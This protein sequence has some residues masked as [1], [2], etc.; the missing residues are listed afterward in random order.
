MLCFEAPDNYARTPEPK[1]QST[2]GGRHYPAI[3]MPQ[4]PSMT[5]AAHAPVPGVRRAP[6]AA[7]SVA[8][9]ILALAIIPPATAEIPFARGSLSLT[10]AL[11]EEYDSNI[12]LNQYRTSDWHTT[13]TP[14]VRLVRDAGL[15]R[16]E[17]D[18]G[19]NIQRF[20]RNDQ[21]NSTDPF[22]NASLRFTEEETRLTG[23]ASGFY[24]RVSEA[25]PD[26]NGRSRVEEKNGKIFLGFFPAQKLGYRVNG[27][28]FDQ[29]F[30]NP[31][32]SDIKTYSLG[33][34]ARYHYSEKF[35]TFV[36]VGKRW[37]DTY[38]VPVGLPS[39]DSED[40]KFRVGVEGDLLAKVSGQFAV[41][42]VR[43]TFSTTM[44][45]ARS[46]LLFDT[47]LTWRPDDETSVRLLVSRDFDT[48]PID[49][50]VM[51]QV[52]G[53]ELHRRIREKLGAT[54]GYSH[55]V[56]NYIGIGIS[57]RDRSDIFH[58]GADYQLTKTWRTSLHLNY[59][60]TDSDSA[61][62]AYD[63]FV[64]GVNIVAAF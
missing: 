6:A 20:Q 11:D 53:V 35:D 13:L 24:R 12:F 3:H 58:A 50:S 52:T 9:G 60:N 33:L 29:D 30:F 22:A 56:S 39:L 27:E 16:L 62:S 44:T 26:V 54:L 5:P 18:A 34:D 7:R 36:G 48:T 45:S 43:R 19:V 10:A 41:G 28:Y 40:L 49:Q 31:A 14:G 15:L 1:G 42:W 21:E 57:R 46:G 4:N 61:M 37:S 2:V 38:H 23:S 8:F 25:N 47:S 55:A 32:W 59:T 64:G 51:R 63:R 17:A